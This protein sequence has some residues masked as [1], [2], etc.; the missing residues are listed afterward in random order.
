MANKCGYDPFTFKSLG[1]ST[2]LKMSKMV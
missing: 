1:H 2:L